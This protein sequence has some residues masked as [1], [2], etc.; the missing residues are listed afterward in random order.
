MK[1]LKNAGVTVAVLASLAGFGSTAS[2]ATYF[3]TGVDLLG[4]NNVVVNGKN[5]LAGAIKMSVE[6][7]AD[8]LFVFCVDLQHQ[9]S[10]GSYTVPLVYTTGAVTT[11]SSGVLSGT[12]NPLSVLQSGAM[13]TLANIGTAIATGSNPDT[14]K[15]GG[16][17]SAIWAIEYD[18]DPST[19]V[20][21]APVSAYLADYYAF[22][23]SHPKAGY[24]EGIYAVDGKTQGQIPGA[25]PEPAAWALMLLGFGT[26]GVALRRR[27]GTVGGNLI[28]A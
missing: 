9:I 24:G 22:G 4:Y 23:L 21:S 17:Q 3:I 13:Q 26:L 5:E 18:I 11:D 1:L 19:I 7:R 25:V 2:A 10:L 15:L 27:G 6:G 16:I 12:G 14:D 8:P 28:T 20:A